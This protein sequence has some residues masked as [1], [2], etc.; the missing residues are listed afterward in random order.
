FIRERLM[1]NG[2]VHRY[3]AQTPYDGIAT[4][5][6]AFAPCNFWAAEYLANA[7]HDAEA[8]VLFER[9]CG[10]GNDVGLF[11]EEMASKTGA[12]VGNFPQA[13]THVSLISAATA[14]YK[15]PTA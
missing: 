2:M 11:A 13:F 15:H 8:K 5:E 4:P 10:M 12:P 3:R 1:V 9:Y 7:G 14:L 6:N